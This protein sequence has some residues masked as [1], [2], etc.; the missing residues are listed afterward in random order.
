MMTHINRSIT[1]I[2][3]QMSLFSVEDES[4]EKK[5]L[6]DYMRFTITFKNLLLLS[7]FLEKIVY[8]ITKRRLICSFW[9]LKTVQMYHT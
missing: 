2:D 1:F 5:C 8:V 3:I 7:F 6:D 4:L 9:L